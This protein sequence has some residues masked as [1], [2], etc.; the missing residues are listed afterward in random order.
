LPLQV[1]CA[2]GVHLFPDWWAVAETNYEGAPQCWGR[3]TEEVIS[4][5]EIWNATHAIIYQESSSNLDEKWGKEFE[6]ISD[7]D[8][9][10]YQYLFRGVDLWSSKQP[11]PKWFL[12]R[13][14]KRLP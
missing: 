13:Y 6:L 14:K 10:R 1:A 3:S 9:S 4:N 11:T 12:L 8:W 7:F 2:K 5:C